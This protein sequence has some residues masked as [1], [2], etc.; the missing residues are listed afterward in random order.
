MERF[1]KY[2]L[3]VILYGALIIIISSIPGLNKSRIA[4]LGYDKI[5][6]FLEYAI[7]AF[8][9]F[10]SFIRIRFISGGNARYVPYL[11]FLF[12]ALFAVLDELFQAG[13]PGRESDILDIAFDILGG[14]LVISILHFRRRNYH[15]RGDNK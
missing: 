12:L 15:K 3:P 11:S 2:H 9:L 10:R 5:I 14:L 7:F 4:V 6:H 8:L 1:L 13:V